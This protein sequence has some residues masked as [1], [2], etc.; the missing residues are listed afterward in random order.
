VLIVLALALL[1]SAQGAGETAHAPGMPAKSVGQTNA[2]IP[3]DQIGAKAGTDYHGDGLAVTPATDGARLHCVFQR[4]DGE[5][6]REGLWLVSTV[7]NTVDDRF[8]VKAAAIGRTIEKVQADLTTTGKVAVDGQNVSFVRPGLTEEYSVSMDGVQQDFVVQE[9]PAGAGELRVQLAVSGAQVTQ[10]AYGAQLIL[11]QSGRKIAYNRL[12]VTDATGKELSARLEAGKELTVVVNDAGAVYPVR[13]DPT[14]SDANWISMGGVPGV[15]G[16]VNAAVVDGSGNLYIGGYFSIVDNT[17]ANCIAKWNGSSWSALGLGLNSTVDALAVSG[18]TLY[19]GGAFTTAT[20]SGNVAVAAN[21]IAQWNGSNWSALGSGMSGYVLA[22]AVS[23]T[24]LYA[25]GVFTTAGVVAANY[26]AEWN[27]SSWSALGSGMNNWVQAL[28]VSGTN[29]YA[30]GFFTAAGGS[31]VNYIAQ[32]NG[33]SWNAL[34]SGMN[35]WVQSLL[36]SGSTLYAGG[37]FTTATN[38]GNVAVAALC[39]A[40]WD[41]NSWTALGSGVNGEVYSLA[42]SGSTLYVGGVFKTAGG[43]TANYIAKWQNGIWSALG[44]GMNNVVSA[45]AVSGNNLYA[46]GTFTSADGVAQS[47][48]AEWNGSSWSVF[49]SG[50]NSGVSALAVSGSTLYAG[51]DFLTAGGVAANYI[52]Q[53]NG[54]SWSALGSGMNGGVL[55]LAV[56]GTNLYAGGDFTT[57]GG[58]LAFYI[59]QWDGSNWSA[60]G[61]GMNSYVSALAVSGTNLYAGG[62][63]TTAGGVAANF[64]AQWNGSSWNTLGS[65]MNSDVIALAESGS[66]LYVGGQFTTAGGTTANYI[67]QWNTNNWSA[68]GSGMGGASYPVVNALAVSGSTLY[69]G[70]WFSTAGGVVANDIAQWNGSSWNALGSGMGGVSYPVVYALAVSGGTLYVGGHFTTATNSGNVA[71]AANY[72]AQWNGS[73]W[74]ALGSGMNGNVFALAVDGSGNLYAGGAFTMAG[75]KVSANA[76]EALFSPPPAFVIVT[77]SGNFGFAN[78]QFR[79]MLTGPAGSNAVIFA[80]TNLHNWIP[81]A[82][83]P[84]MGGSLSFTDKLATNFPSRFYR[85]QLSP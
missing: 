4:F 83:N 84:L 57:A 43:G 59:A 45:L 24:N 56:S 78:K 41:G 11:N 17:T 15:N 75:G 32:W 26:I 71:V 30:G 12:R 28:A 20:N 14:F 81:L 33:S 55:A 42:V 73:S 31:T 50:M 39:I 2:P 74:S 63:F 62:D 82:T 49:G 23:G 69:A 85:A 19:V 65:G 8:Q 66:T 51:G 13:I 36:V 40:Q 10:T 29:L 68:L 47:G 46:G 25:G 52:A 60:L 22:L 72:I 67:A 16:R 48:V 21:Y 53:W 9:K 80:S 54:S 35:N 70:G 64:I 18:S 79:F 6:T 5:A 76:A 58:N 61:S 37:N 38:S 77:T 3:W 7:T 1:T 44:S 27:G 34:G